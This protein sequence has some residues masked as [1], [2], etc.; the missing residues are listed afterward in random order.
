M[1]EPA[2]K[3]GSGIFDEVEY[4]YKWEALNRREWWNL[5]ISVVCPS[6]G[7]FQVINRKSDLYETGDPANRVKTGDAEFDRDCF[8]DTNLKQFTLDFLSEES[9]RK[10]VLEL[11]RQG[12]ASVSNN[13]KKLFADWTQ[14]EQGGFLSEADIAKAAQCLVRL[15]QNAVS[16]PEDAPEIKEA[17]RLSTLRFFILLSSLLPI[18]LVILGVSYLF[19]EHSYK[20]LDS[21]VWIHSFVF[22]VPILAIYI[23]TSVR[24]ILRHPALESIANIKYVVLG[25]LIGFPLLGMGIFNGLNGLL[26]KHNPD[27]HLTTVTERKMERGSYYAVVPSWRQKKQSEKIRITSE[28]YKDIIPG[29]TKM[30]ITTKPGFF[31]YEWVVAY[32]GE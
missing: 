24:F 17:K 32:E 28:E 10:A 25:S 6:G 9:K 1:D 2:Q 7:N 22:T 14:T 26:D 8:L 27:L 23:F 29:E 19:G 21:S 16:I 15:S 12:F 3:S 5:E 30:E 20:P 31:H 4:Q 18:L 11:F 13:G